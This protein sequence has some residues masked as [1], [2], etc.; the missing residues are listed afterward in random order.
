MCLMG[1]KAKLI[2]ADFQNILSFEKSVCDKIG[3]H[4]RDYFL[5]MHFVSNVGQKSARNV[6]IALNVRGVKQIGFILHFTFSA[7]S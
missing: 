4:S 5:P 6:M 7:I 1:V 3:L 2:S